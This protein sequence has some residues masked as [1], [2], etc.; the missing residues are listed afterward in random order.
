MYE[1]KTK[2]VMKILVRKDK[3][4]FNFS[5]S[6]AK[7]KYYYDLIQTNYL[8][9]RQKMKREMLVLKNLLD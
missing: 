6:S 1:I 8:L 2:G 7:S 5:N 3:E 4:M 9:L